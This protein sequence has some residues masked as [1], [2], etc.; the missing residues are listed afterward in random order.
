M[1]ALLRQILDNQKEDRTE[2]HETQKVVV[3][4]DKK[5]SLVCKVQ[6]DHDKRITVCENDLAPVRDKR[7]ARRHIKEQV[8][9]ATLFLSP[10]LGVMTIVLGW[11]KLINLFK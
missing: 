1:E 7:S 8:K 4:M 3:E 5:L 9:T 11:E 2:R 10:V 6:G